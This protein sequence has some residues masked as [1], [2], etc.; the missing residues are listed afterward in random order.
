MYVVNCRIF[1]DVIAAQLFSIQDDSTIYIEDDDWKCPHL[2][3][4]HK[5]TCQPS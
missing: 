2:D 1:T 5:K 3:K 4:C